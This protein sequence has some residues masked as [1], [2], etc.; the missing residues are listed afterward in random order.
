MLSSYQVQG[1]RSTGFGNTALHVHSWYLF[2]WLRSSDPWILLVILPLV[3]AMHPA[4]LTVCDLAVLL[5]TQLHQHGDFTGG[6]WVSRVNRRP[7]CHYLLEA[8]GGVKPHRLL[9]QLSCVHVCMLSGF[10]SDSL[11]P[12]G[13]KPARLLCAG[14]S[15]GKSAGVGC[16]AL[17]FPTQGSNPHLL[18]LLHWLA[19]SY[20]WC[21]HPA[22]VAQVLTLVLRRGVWTVI[23]SLPW[24]W[25]NSERS[26][27][28]HNRFW[29]CPAYWNC[30]RYGGWKHTLH[31]SLGFVFV[32]NFS[33]LFLLFL[34][35]KII[36]LQCCVHFCHTT[37]ISHKY[38]YV[39]TH[40]HTHTHISPPIK[41][42]ISEDG[43][44]K[45]DKCLLSAAECSGS[46]PVSSL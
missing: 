32:F 21:S 19:V 42:G 27:F 30:P 34:N 2:L 6:K 5:R 16:C 44:E 8:K 43:Y 3:L 26:I 20:H 35:W 15:P 13:L 24:K 18:R 28:Y 40:T 17:F 41:E 11:W 36:S 10:M 9:L 46:L 14:D 37:W 31:E 12:R 45:N 25:N 33:I 4:L 22:S 39:C 29:Q 7:G 23:F 38:I 1:P